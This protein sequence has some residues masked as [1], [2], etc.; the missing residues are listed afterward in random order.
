MLPSKD[1]LPNDQVQPANQKFFRPYKPLLQPGQKHVPEPPKFR[2][3]DSGSDSD[4]P[5][6]DIESDSGID[7][8]T[9]DTDSSSILSVE[10]ANF[11]KLATNLQI[12]QASGPAFP[13]NRD[14]LTYGVN[15]IHKGV[16]YSQY[17][18]AF[19]IDIVQANKAFDTSGIEQWRRQDQGPKQ[20]ITSII[21]LNSRDRDRNVYPLPTNLTLRLPR[22]YQNV[23]SLQVVQMKLLSSFLYFREDKNNLS[24]TINE[25]GRVNYNF[26]NQNVGV[27]NITKR[28][29]EGSYNINS[30]IQELNIQLNTPP[31][32]Y[33][34]PG[35][36][37]QFVPLFVSTGDFGLAFNFPGE[38]FYDSLNRTFTTAPTRNFI[39]QQ[40]WQTPTIGFTPN[41]TQ[42]SVAYYYPVLKEVVLDP[43][44]G[45]V[46]LILNTST[47]NPADIS[48]ET[49]EDRV[50]F[51]FL[52]VNDPVI[53]ALIQANLS[54]L[55]EYRSTKT[56]RQS[57][58]NRYIVSYETFNNRINIQTTSLNTSLVNL[59][60]TQFA[61]FFAQQLSLAGITQAQFNLLVSL[62]N[63]LLSIVN[64]MYEYI[65]QELAIYFGVN[66]NTYAASY[67]TNPDFFVLVQ[68]ALGATNV[69]SNYDLAVLQA[70]NTPITTNIIE[71]VRKNPLKLWPNMIDLGNTQA[72]NTNLGDSN[73]E[74][75][76]GTSNTPY[77]ITSANFDS[78]RSFI[79]ANGDVFIDLSR[80]A[81]DILTPIDAGKYTLFR[82][83]SLYRQT[84]QV[85][86]LPR[87]TQYRYPAYNQ[88]SNSTQ[89]ATF[90]DNSYSYVFNSNNFKMDNVPDS[91]LLRLPGFSNITG[92]TSNFG[93]TFT[94][95]ANL[96]GATSLGVDVLSNQYNFTFT[97]PSPPTGLP[98]AQTHSM[99]L[100][101]INS[102][103]TSNLPSDLLLFLYHDR[104]GFMADLSG[105]IRNENP[106]HYKFLLPI[107]SNVISNTLNW[108]A[109]AGETYYGILR[110]SN[111][112]FTSLNVRI[113]PWYPDGSNFIQL[114]DSLS[115]NA[116]STSNF[117]PFG[118]PFDNLN[119]YNYAQ[120]YD[121]NFIRLPVNSNLWGTEPTG[122]EVNTGIT[123][124]N[125]PIGY[126]TNNVSTDLT[127]YL[128]Y[129]P[130]VN[131]SNVNPFAVIRVDPITQ[132]LFQVGSPYSPSLQTYLY[133]SASNFILSPANQTPYTPSNVLERQF[134]IVHWYDNYFLPDPVGASNTY[135]P[136]D[137][138]SQTLPYSETTTIVALS[139]YS[140]IGGSI[141]LGL[142]VC[143]F[144]FVPADGIFDVD[145]VVFKSALS[146]VLSDPNS[147]IAYLGIYPTNQVNAL[148]FSDILLSDALVKL[149]SNVFRY[150]PASS[151]FGYT[152]QGG[153]YYE[154]IRDPSWPTAAINGFTQNAR[155]FINDA[156]SF[157]SVLAFDAASNVTLIHALAGGPTP[158]S[159]VSDASASIFYF[160]GERAPINRGI[161]MPLPPS[162]PNSNAYPPPGIDYSLSQY[163]QSFT[164]GTNI[165]NFL[166]QA[167]LAEDPN[168]FYPWPNLGYSPSM[169]YASIANWFMTQDTEFK[170]Y[171]YTNNT[172]N[173]DFLYQYSLTVDTIF[174]ASESTSL[175]AASGNNTAFAFLGFRVVPGAFEV[176]IKMYDPNQG[177]L[178]D[179]GVPPSFVIPDLGFSVRSFSITDGN[180]FVISGSSGTGTAVSYRTPNLSTPFF[181]D[182]F[183]GYV[184]VKGV[185]DP[186]LSTVF[187]L[188]LNGSGESLGVYFGQDEQLSEASRD[189]YTFFGEDIP[190][191]L[192]DILVTRD[193]NGQNELLFLS[194]EPIAA[195]RFLKLKS[196]SGNSPNFSSLLLRS[197]FIFTN[198]IG[199]P[200][201]AL[202]FVG[203]AGGSKWAYFSEN[204]T[205]Y[206][207]RNDNV[208]APIRVQNAWQIFYPV[209][210]IVMRKIAN[211][212]NPITDLSGLEYPEWP[213]TNMFAYSSEA[214]MFED[215]SG[216][217]GLESS[218]N[219]LVSDVNFRGFYFN[220]YIFNVPLY[221]Q[222]NTNDYTF[223]TVRNYSPS[224]KSQILLRFNM[225][226]RF[227]F[228][229]VR[230]TDLSNEPFFL[231]QTGA[232]ISFNPTYALALSN[233]NQ[234]FVFGVSNSIFGAPFVPP[235]NFGYNPTQNI[236]GSNITSFSFGDFLR[237]YR[238][239][240]ALYN[241]NV[242]LIDTINSNVNSLMNQFILDNLIY[243]LPSNALN[244]QGFTE[245]IT[246]SILW[247]S[248]LTPLYLSLEDEWGLGWNL[249]YPKRDT[250]YST[251]QRADSFFK[252]LDDYIY[253]KLNPEYDM[254]RVDFGAKEN[255]SRT[256]EP[257]GQIRGFN[258]KLLLNTFGNYAQ[259]I[260]Q[261]PVYFN[262]PS[263][264]LDKLQFQWIDLVGQVIDNAEC[265]WNAAIQIV[266]EVLVP[267]IRGTN[268]IIIP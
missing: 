130:G 189:T 115:S 168:A 188:P 77:L 259:T 94:D 2:P 181:V 159:Y 141:Q 167:D 222:S 193:Q 11:V 125:V 104:G 57:L 59:L 143:G 12:N 52:G 145:R 13:T 117:T 244:R 92:Y 22:V 68:N 131:N 227:D 16:G 9:N 263:L 137:I 102:N 211:E 166:A 5:D 236:N 51:Y 209:Q 208:D 105:N 72:Y 169:I 215:I 80:K 33:D 47:V 106:L 165:T 67:F 228:G 161:V 246:F 264:R 114:T 171:T 176:R 262:P 112:A 6:S 49:I 247:R 220:S 196:V 40:F 48:G 178:Y 158:Y 267:Q 110:S 147:N 249:G 191:F 14:Q 241:S 3:Y 202:S 97:L 199:N 116:G 8:S 183:V 70:G 100:T 173:R 79:N 136:A 24:I 160:D 43:L 190:T 154:F 164:I 93:N 88:A 41:L 66:F 32:F 17:E 123:I 151:N 18:S 230:L 103:T 216:K 113:V 148:A 39:I 258:G 108:T 50:V 122:N 65:Q 62:N 55:D 229:F 233:F 129:L 156:Q 60:N 195:N 99:N 121:S 34:Y 69:S 245:S 175:V 217:W 53:Q 237:Q 30:L 101:V 146:N 198:T 31:L 27:L 256:N 26:L 96:W 257:T 206:G 36:F 163:E 29:R 162:G 63:A 248:S 38:Y 252:I 124:S 223:L 23:Q 250:S 253:L 177:I 7:I 71:L 75:F 203:G 111:I 153:A 204:P 46:P 4:L 144:S 185:Q 118:D 89:I 140:Y 234:Q 78:N 226:Q 192:T 225:P 219:F 180:G 239:L 170:L 240:F 179:L 212:P 128:G 133:P 224:E 19:N 91:S 56:F 85:E 268:P 255:L 74:P 187:Y 20:N 42:T 260:I 205:I 127:D 182:T 150:F 172:Q 81:S 58:I 44:Y 231:L 254:N 242:A 86:T 200:M 76:L 95:S 210:K 251:I 35:G 61:I 238:N 83:R 134:K 186:S 120:V 90:F 174:P 119:N 64:S 84:L 98:P 155:T 28:I 25:F 214:S 201:S 221:P 232:D 149:N 54:L 142:G 45:Q 184:T 135:N 82:F 157:Y 213:H 87:P 243:I 235:R 266:E 109:Y 138:D 107:T 15:R 21:M 1:I 139:N 218:S 207:N 73:I 194:S 37:N 126:D 197:I 152:P 261:N 10:G 132:F 265:E